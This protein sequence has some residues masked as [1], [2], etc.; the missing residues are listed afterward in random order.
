[1]EPFRLRR[2]KA[3]APTIA[4]RQIPALS[5]FKVTAMIRSLSPGQKLPITGLLVLKAT[6]AIAF[7]TTSK[8]F[9]ARLIADNSF[10]VICGHIMCYRPQKIYP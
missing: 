9:I 6:L 1:M 4:R 7:K 3:P 2:W 5:E 8:T 10:A